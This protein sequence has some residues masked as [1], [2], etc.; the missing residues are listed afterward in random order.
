[1]S[2]R[3]LFM[4]SGLCSVGLLLGVL[5][6]MAT[7]MATATVNGTSVGAG[8]YNYNITLNDTGS[9]PVGTFWFS[10]VPGAG[11]LS[12][13]PTAYGSPAGWS[14][15]T[16]NAGAGIQWTTTTDLLAAGSSLSGF[17]FTSTET[18]QQLMSTVTSGSFTD[19]ATVFYIYSGAPFSDAG[20]T[21]VAAVTTTPEPS[22][23]LLLGTGLLAAVA[24]MRRR[25]GVV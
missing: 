22:S 12:P 4:K 24:V 21:S 20:Y 8:V 19:P 17:D 7:E 14:E 18:P 3:S 1:M 16:T 23:F 6:A 2:L 15:K 5:P 11:F 25:Y 10:W 13:A 9:T